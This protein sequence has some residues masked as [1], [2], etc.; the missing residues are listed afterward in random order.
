M[1][2]TNG[3][4]FEY[5]NYLYEFFNAYTHM[6]N[7]SW[8]GCPGAVIL[9]PLR[10]LQGRLA[11]L[12]VIARTA[13]FFISRSSSWWGMQASNIK[14]VDVDNLSIYDKL[15]QPAYR[16]GPYLHIAKAHNEDTTVHYLGRG[17]GRSAFSTTKV[18][19]STHFLHINVL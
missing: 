10:S 15:K 5:T 13:T 19:G 1:I 8:P 17:I 18:P 9:D 4:I 16:E 7:F 3:K 11:S 6:G 14:A 2:G 12:S